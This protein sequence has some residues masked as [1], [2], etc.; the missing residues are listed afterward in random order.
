MGTI[1][2]LTVIKNFTFGALQSLKSSDVISDI[3]K[4]T[5]WV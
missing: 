4:Q 1:H 2:L 5:V 3:K